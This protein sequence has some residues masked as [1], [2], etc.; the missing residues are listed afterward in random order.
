MPWLDLLGLNTMAGTALPGVPVEQMITTENV[1]VRVPASVVSLVTVV[2]VVREK[3]KS[4]I[5][6]KL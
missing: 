2:T 4:Q 3:S 6:C 1:P 5:N